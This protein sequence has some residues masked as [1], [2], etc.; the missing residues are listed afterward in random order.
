MQKTTDVISLFTSWADLYLQ[1]LVFFKSYKL[2]ISFLV[3]FNPALESTSPTFASSEYCSGQF[4]S[5]LIIDFFSN[6]ISQNQHLGL[7]TTTDGRKMQLDYC[8]SSLKELWLQIF[9]QDL[10]CSCTGKVM[11]GRS[12]LCHEQNMCCTEL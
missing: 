5:N 3:A 9:L 8:L 11:C 4:L 10:V 2:A 12:C 6:S 7:L 1:Q